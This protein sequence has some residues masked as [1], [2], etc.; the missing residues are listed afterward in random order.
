MDAETRYQLVTIRQDQL[1][2]EAEA[3]RL[4]ATASRT[5]PD[6]SAGSAHAGRSFGMLRRLFGASTGLVATD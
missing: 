5:R 1:R 3:T 4:A 2:A 6:H